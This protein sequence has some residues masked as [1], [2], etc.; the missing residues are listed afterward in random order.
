MNKRDMKFNSK[1]AG[2]CLSRAKKSKEMGVSKKFLNLV[3]VLI[4]YQK[5]Q[6]KT[7]ALVTSHLK[8]VRY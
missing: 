4:E 1:K 8:V 5:S 3:E 2:Q 6:N 7:L